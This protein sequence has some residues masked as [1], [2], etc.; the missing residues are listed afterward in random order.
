[1]TNEKPIADARA[2]G[3]TQPTI[4]KIGMADLGD[5]LAK[6]VADFNAMPTHLIFICLIYPI[7]MLIAARVA[8][9][10]E[11][12]PLVFPLLAGYTLIG[13]LFAVG[14]YELSRRREKGLDISRR[15]AFDILRLPSIRPIA[16]LGVALMAIYFA[17][18]FAA[19]TIYELIF[20]GAVPA[21]IGEFVR[22][23]LTTP[24]GFALIVVG[25]SVGFLFAA[26]VFALSVVSF[27]LLLDRDVSAV[28][29]ATTSVRA[30]LANPV[31]MAMW[32]FM[33]A[34]ALLIGALPFFV[35]LAVV[36]PVLGHST[37]HLYRKVVES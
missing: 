7:A 1:M 30:V 21:S 9:G 10:H 3:H 14:M 22:Q 13:P 18:L 6:G 2:Y 23:I 37:W 35:G 15:H 26:A 36:L 8:A 19:Q 31:T 28:T 27:P 17:W 4:R 25:C 32:G 20:G 5:A 11:V 16:E 34:A 24:S 33:V 12:L 29:A